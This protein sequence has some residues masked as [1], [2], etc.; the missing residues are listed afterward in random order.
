MLSNTSSDQAVSSISIHR[1]CTHLY[2]QLATLCHF[3]EGYV[4]VGEFLAVEA[5]LLRVYLT[6]LGH[7]P[8]GLIS[9]DGEVLA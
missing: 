3:G 2:P 9:G 5:V 8:K 1:F 6:I 4:R 7:R